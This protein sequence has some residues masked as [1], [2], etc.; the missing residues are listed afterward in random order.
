MPTPN[1]D[2]LDREL[3]THLD[4]ETEE[5]R[6]ASLSAAQAANAARRALGNPTYLK[7]DLRAVWHWTSLER[8]AQ[9]LRYAFRTL[10]N[11]PA[12]T[13]VALLALILGIGGN[14]AMFTVVNAVLL[15]PLPFRDPARLAAI[16]GT[17]PRLAQMPMS[18]A[19][20]AEY[21]RDSKSFSEILA[22]NPFSFNITGAA[23]AERVMGVQVSANFFDVLGAQ[24]IQGRT[25]L[26]GED[27][28]GSNRVVVLSHAMWRRQFGGDPA[29]IG[30][31]VV[32]NGA[33]ATVVGVMPA[34][35][36][37]PYSAGPIDLWTPLALR[38]ED[39]ASR[40]P[41][42]LF[43]VGRLTPE[44][45]L[46][47]ARSEMQA[48]AARLAATYPKANANVGI[49]LVPLHEQVVGRSRP[50]LLLLFGAVALVLLIACANVANLL[51]ARASTRR[52]E[53]ALRTALGASSGRV[54]RQ[55]ITE[56]LLVAVIAGVLGVF[57]GFGVVRLLR[58]AFPPGIPRL[59]EMKLDAAVFAFTL[60][61]AVLTGLIFG[62]LPAFHMSRPGRNAS[63]HGAGRRVGA[64]SGGFA[65]R[66][67]VAAEMALALVVA[68][69]AGLLVE[70]FRRLETVP[71][72]F[73][74]D[75]L[76]TFTIWPSEK[77]YKDPALREA[78]Y[79]RVLERVSALSGVLG[80]GSVAYPPMGGGC[81]NGSV[82]IQGR[83]GESAQFHSDFNTASAGYFIAAGI[84]LRMG[85][86]FTNRDTAQA[87]PVAIIT[88]SFARQVFPAENPLGKRITFLDKT[89]EIVGVVG[90]VRQVPAQ[91]P[92]PAAYVPSA[93]N[94]WPFVTVAVRTAAD[95]A[96]AQALR[97]NV[98]TVD[99]DQPVFKLQSADLT[100]SEALAQPRFEA[101]LMG[102]FASIAALLAAVGL[103]GLTSY[104]V[105]QRTSEIGVR[106]ALGAQRA[107]VLGMVVRQSVGLV[108]AGIPVGVL[109]ALALNRA[110]SAFVFG[111][112]TTD[113]VT[114][115]FVALL[116]TLIAL[117]AVAAPAWRA[118]RVDPLVALRYE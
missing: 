107:Q 77:Q 72:G 63:L 25:L 100:L 58:N 108:A 97:Q 40:G 111:V 49:R 106:M 94:P 96:G 99:P 70:S 52:N 44:A 21:Q 65:G 69:G 83:T 12:F 57:F 104:W 103:Y 117:V 92:L 71:V 85:R 46:D 87:P 66:A 13:V 7:E 78:Y 53:L 50:S 1:D 18:A 47:R 30:K 60:G 62:V 3:R 22:Y 54:L 17:R 101:M 23:S 68:I 5:Q 55:L 76:T 112:S 31:T 2:D 86:Y 26:A 20:F 11:T 93:Q 79:Q 19:D 51:L 91:E 84:P 6:A 114:F 115:A 98:Q 45:S 10:R 56:N 102:V 81:A 29:A 48:I 9:D 34:D 43:A 61:I 37:F 67:L 89:R 41:R 36:T 42:S 105:A 38:P 35:F 4:L 118:T 8:L 88:E 15:R 28:A 39:L 32:L 24:A 80:A 73:N 64:A 113:P 27:R 110:L 90:D 59:A 109:V 75:Q 95:Y 116:L 14:T 16:F 33:S 82:N 74:P